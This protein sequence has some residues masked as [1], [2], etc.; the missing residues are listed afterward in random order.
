MICWKIWMTSCTRPCLPSIIFVIL[1]NQRTSYLH[2]LLNKIFLTIY[3][4]PAG[5]RLPIFL[6]TH[7][8]TVPWSRW[9]LSIYIYLLLRTHFNI[10]IPLTLG[11]QSGR[12]PTNFRIDFWRP[13][14]FM[15]LPCVLHAKSIS[16]S[17]IRYL[18]SSINY[19]YCHWNFNL[20]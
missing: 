12:F 8:L 9:N 14:C 1:K 13:I 6:G 4:L 20:R 5:Q 11:F 18:V 17:L 10:I 16:L 7:H 2:G 19:Y 3:V 15:S